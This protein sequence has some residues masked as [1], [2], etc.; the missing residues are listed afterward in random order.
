MPDIA[1]YFPE[2]LEE[3][4]ALLAKIGVI[5]HAGGTGI[6]KGRLRSV[7]GL[8]D[9]SRLPLRTFDA[10]GGF[11]DLGA[12][13]TYA[14][15]ARHMGRAE[16]SHV[17]VEALS[18]AASTPLRNRITL[19][20]SIAFYPL[21]SDL[22]GPLIAL[23]TELSLAGP[24]SGGRA[25][26]C[27]LADYVSRAELRKGKLITAVHVKT[28]RWEALYHRETRTAADYP[29]FTATVLLKRRSGAAAD[30]R[31]VLSGVKGKYRRLTELEELFNG[32]GGP[33][34][35]T[36]AAVAEKLDADF[37]PKRWGGAEYMKQLAVVALHRALRRALGK[38]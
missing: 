14:D 20:G 7:K 17:L 27:P 3:V 9:L 38:G 12:T 8:I 25:A 18:R 11:Y 24:E 36:E 4:P 23:D 28:E 1:W 33:G 29:A 37:G 13:L 26:R 19:G 21:W 31:I 2:S 34:D 10:H 30:S 35:V 15:A 16:P 32:A 5:P 22:M 6:L